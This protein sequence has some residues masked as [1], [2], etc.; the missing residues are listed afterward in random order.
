MADPRYSAALIGCG[1]MGS[2]YMD[3]LAGLKSRTVLPV[4]HAEVLKTLSKTHLIAGADSHKERLADFG[5]RWEVTRLY[6]DHR[7]MLEKENPAVVSIA[8]PPTLHSRHVIDCAER[9]VKGIFCEKPLAPTLREADSMIR[10]CDDNGVKLS[11]NHTLRGDPYVLQTRKLID[12]GEIGDILTI[13]CTWPGRLFLTGTH[14][15]DLVN[16]FAGDREPAWLFGHIEEP[17]AAMMAVPTQRGI[18]VGGTAYCVYK[19]GIRAFFNG[20]DGQTYRRTTISGSQG[21]LIVDDYD[22]GLWKRNP[23]S[24]FSELLAYPFPQMMR[25]T[26]PMV[27][28]LEDLIEAMESDRDPMSSGRTARRALEQILATHYSSQKDNGKVLFPFDDLD[29]RPPFQWKDETD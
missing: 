5:N 4:G 1:S 18:D 10:A 8:S 29:M 9:G 21:L 14:S 7:E 24:P 19:S 20:R 23:E 26:A 11:I 28:L 15:Y 17:D 12:D 13:T 22:A 6:S 27:Y 2:Y 3:E 25:F 16:F